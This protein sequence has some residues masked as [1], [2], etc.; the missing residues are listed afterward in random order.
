MR[1]IRQKITLFNA[2]D[3]LENTILLN[4]HKIAI[5]TRVRTF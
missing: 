1:S 3:K 5:I 2:E 4:E